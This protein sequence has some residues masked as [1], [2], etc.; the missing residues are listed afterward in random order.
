MRPERDLYQEK[1][2]RRKSLGA[3][4]IQREPGAAK[5]FCQKEP[6]YV[7]NREIQLSV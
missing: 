5:W 6:S 2:G 4:Q 7:T 3:D 1:G